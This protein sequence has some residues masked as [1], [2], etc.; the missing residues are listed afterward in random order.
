MQKNTA[1]FNTPPKQQANSPCPQRH[2]PR[3]QRKK[4]THKAP[5]YPLCHPVALGS[6]I[7]KKH[8]NSKNHNPCDIHNPHIAVK[9]PITVT[10]KIL[11]NMQQNAPS[12]KKQ[13]NKEITDVP[14]AY[15]SHKPP[16]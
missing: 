4:T 10:S 14:P 11:A 8:E 3:P 5:K 7:K 6:P 16:A 15:L 9:S 13:I 1:P 12:F 2:C